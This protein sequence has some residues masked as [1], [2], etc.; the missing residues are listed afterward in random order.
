MTMTVTIC[1]TI[2]ID[3]EIDL[4]VTAGTSDH[5][6]RSLGGPGGWSP[7]SPPEAE[8]LEIRSA[9][10]ARLNIADELTRAEIASIHDA[11]VEQAIEADEDAEAAA[12]DDERD[13]RRDDAYE[14]K[15]ED[16]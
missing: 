2:E 16:W 11:A 8:I 13:R 1:R 12:A 3:V 7:G 9:G 5:Y 14:R 10:G 4:E 15:G 6:D